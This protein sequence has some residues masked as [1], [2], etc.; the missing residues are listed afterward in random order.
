MSYEWEFNTAGRPL[1]PVGRQCHRGPM[2]DI[3]IVL[4]RKYSVV[5]GSETLRSRLL[6]HIVDTNLLAVQTRELILRVLDSNLSSIFV[7]LNRDKLKLKVDICE[8]RNS[9]PIDRELHAW[10]GDYVQVATRLKDFNVAP[11][12]VALLL[13]ALKSTNPVYRV[14]AR[15]A[16]I[17][18]VA[19]V[20]QQGS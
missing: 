11:S 4:S 20:E 14:A 10:D 7:E 9:I 18:M 16:I 13:S 6:A 19:Y 5:P 8:K 1:S 3:E 15:C 2:L 12:R 17:L